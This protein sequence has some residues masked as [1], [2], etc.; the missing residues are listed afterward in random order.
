MPLPDRPH[1]H[2]TGGYWLGQQFDLSFPPS[3]IFAHFARDSSPAA[4]VL[5]CPSPPPSRRTFI[6]HSPHRC[7]ICASHRQ[8]N[9]S[10][11]PAAVSMA[12][13]YFQYFGITACCI[14][15][16]FGVGAL[17][18]QFPLHRHIFTHM[19]P[20][21]PTFQQ[22]PADCTPGFPHV[23]QHRA[24]MSPIQPHH[25]GIVGVVLHVHRTPHA[26]IAVLYQA[27]TT[28][29]LVDSP[30]PIIAAVLLHVGHYAPACKRNAA[31]WSNARSHGGSVR[32]S[33]RE[34][35][36][37]SGHSLCHEHVACH[38]PVHTTTGCCDTSY[39][40]PSRVTPSKH[41]ILRLHPP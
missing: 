5:S 40:A 20:S 4:P 29:S 9:K 23:P 22:W 8:H 37:T 13:I 38:A 1:R 30:C 35:N 26:G 12:T 17:H 27:N 24:T 14:H 25:Q 39:V 41:F 28:C 18:L 15:S 7:Q 19:P 33:P 36:T 31:S 6:L 34:Y 16:N 10:T 32:R 11:T 3:H 2:Y 21:G